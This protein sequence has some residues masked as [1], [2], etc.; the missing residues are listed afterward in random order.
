MAL[1]D[2]NLFL[3]AIEKVRLIRKR[4]KMAQSHKSHISRMRDIEF[5]IEDWIYLKV[6]P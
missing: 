1:T 2:L 5:D 3:L 6:S 4:L